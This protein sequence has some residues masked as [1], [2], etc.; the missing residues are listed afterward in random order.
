MLGTSSSA[1]RAAGRKKKRSV[2]RTIK[3]TKTN[4]SNVFPL[5][6]IK[7]R[8]RLESDGE[9]I[10]KQHRILE[11]VKC[12]GGGWWREGRKRTRM[13]AGRPGLGAG[14]GGD[15]G[16][17]GGGDEGG[18]NGFVKQHGSFHVKFINLEYGED[19]KLERFSCVRDKSP[20]RGIFKRKSKSVTMAVCK[21][22]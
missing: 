1:R 8:A 20:S 18:K 15:G 17:G 9:N 3:T 5:K 10:A 16:R 2:S 12:A 19:D 22:R 21:R 14:D 7:I 11:T 6:N 13:V 4:N